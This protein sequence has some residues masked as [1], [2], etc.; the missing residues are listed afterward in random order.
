MVKEQPPDVIDTHSAPAATPGVRTDETILESGAPGL[1]NV[2][3]ENDAKVQAQEQSARQAAA[4]TVRE[5]NGAVL[6]ILVLAVW[7]GLATLSYSTAPASLLGLSL[8][9]SF[10]LF[11]SAW[12]MLQQ[13][14]A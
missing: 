3:V 2:V 5:S 1:T 9:A 10:L 14:R 12:S 11:S 7:L 6:A 8:I 13:R 4:A